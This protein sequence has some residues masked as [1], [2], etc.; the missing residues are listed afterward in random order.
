MRKPVYVAPLTAVG[1]ISASALAYEILLTRIFAII[2]WHDLVATAI[3][4]ALLG[5]GASGTFLTIVGKRLQ[6]YFAPVFIANALLFSLSSLGCVWLA[7][8]LPFD[9]QAL[10]WDPQQLLYLT[11]T[12]LI[13]AIP[14]FAAANCIGLS[15][16]TFQAQIP[17]LYGYDLIGA[18]LGAALLLAGLAAMSPADNL[19]GIFVAGIVV[20]ITAALTLRWQRITV[21]VASLLILALAWTVGRPE[22][23]PAAYKDL[24]R[25]LAIAGATL[26][27]S[28]SGVAGT[29]SVVSNDRVPI[30]TAPGLSLHAVAMPPRQLAV[31]IDGDAVGTLHA[32]KSDE[33]SSDYLKDLTSA[34][35][36]RLLDNPRVAVLDAGT[37][38][39]VEQ[40]IRLGAAS[41]NAIEPNHQLRALSCG[42]HVQP[43][44]ERCGPKVEWHT[45]SARAFIA[46]SHAAFDLITLALHADASGLD[47]L[48]ANYDLTHE[49]VASYF[50]RLAP[51][52][53]LAIEGPTRLPPR[54][55]LRAIATARVTLNQLGISEPGKH[56]AAIRGWQR[57]VLLVS[58]APLDAAR[59]A[60]IRS[61][62]GVNGFDLIWLPDIRPDE[63]NRYQ[64]L[65]EP[66]YYLQA[67]TIL[68]PG[69]GPAAGDTSARY[70][71]QAAGDDIPFPNR[72]TSWTEGWSALRQGNRAA[73]SQ[74]D[75]G[76][77]I[78]MATL[79]VVTIS[80][81]L[82]I[83]LP[84]PW[85]GRAASPRAPLG[86]GLRTLLY[87]FLLGIAFLFIEI[88]W[89]QRLQLFLGLPVYATTAVL[90]TFLVFAG[91]GSLWSQNRS[92]A[93]AH[94]V[95]LFAVTAILLSSLV[96]L[97]YMP[98]WLKAAADL[99]LAARGVLVLVLLAPLAFAMGIPFPTGLKGL[100]QTSPQLIPWAWAINGCASVISAAG[101][102]L[103]AM[104]I[105][106][107]G[108]I[109]VAVVAY[110]LLPTIR[111]DRTRAGT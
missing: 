13:L 34:L 64:R 109:T 106:F 11:A 57:F 76:L 25:S 91:L 80:G 42:N 12:F 7:Q 32:N 56:L 108:L 99:P 97:V 66:Q 110:L 92:G 83:L 16:W 29:L 20:A 60:E 6:H 54:L 2:H 93:Q 18:G 35:P 102:P 28:E 85:R 69:N 98:S 81:I 47:A 68:D 94:R 75:T 103:L 5:Y 96:Y 9:P 10:T 33:Q 24:A 48:K 15:L 58:R 50:D 101:A 19:F 84:L 41:V 49:A 53:L 87:F 14:F 27:H 104:E 22:L 70:R 55:S 73:L 95:L 62:A 88:A 21:T 67:K 61:F 74:I 30:R 111:I 105:G 17:R 45:Q 4:L 51:D 23:Q 8:K 43:N 65:S 40:A 59:L 82:L 36:Y 37:G 63:T 71:L 44:P 46:G 26:E 39:G 1:L 100:G 86:Q 90:L 78:A 72:F 77:F 89:I 31:F 38:L 79:A 107:N 3:S 52:G